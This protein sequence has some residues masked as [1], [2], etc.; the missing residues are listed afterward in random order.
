VTDFSDDMPLKPV[1]DSDGTPLQE[2]T[3]RIAAVSG[4]QASWTRD[5]WPTAGLNGQQAIS[6]R[7]TSR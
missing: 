5:D 7:V 3:K 6:R 1:A 4:Q 2:L